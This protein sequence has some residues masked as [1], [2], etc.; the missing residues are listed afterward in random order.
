MDRINSVSSPLFPEWSPSVE[1]MRHRVAGMPD[2]SKLPREQL[3]E[4][5]RR[6][7]ATDRAT[8]RLG[9]KAMVTGT[10]AE[11]PEVRNLRESLLGR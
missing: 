6:I 1:Q 4:A 11:S 2:A 3:T 7:H 5:A 9:L 8:R 10:A